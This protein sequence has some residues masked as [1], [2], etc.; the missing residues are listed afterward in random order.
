MAVS[1]YKSKVSIRGKEKVV[2]VANYKKDDLT[3]EI[4][5]RHHIIIFDRS[6]SMSGE[7]TELISNIKRVIEYIPENDYISILW[8]SGEGQYST[9]VKGARKG[10]KL[11]LL[12]DSVNSTV[13]CTCFSEVLKEAGEIIKELKVIC[14]NFVINLFT[15]GEA[16]TSVSDKEEYERALSNAR[17][18]TNDILALNTIGYGGYYNK[19]FLMELSEM[20]PYGVMCH[21][22]NIDEYYGILVE[23]L[24]R[25]KD[26]TVGELEVMAVNS[27]IMYNTS[28]HTKMTEGLYHTNLLDKTKNQVVIILDSESE[29]N[30]NDEYFNSKDI[31]KEIPSATMIP[32]MYS[33]AYNKYIKG[34]REDSISVLAD[35]LRDKYLVD[36]QFKA[37]S[38][39]E[40]EQYRKALNHAIYS[41]KARLLDGEC[42]E[43]YLPA[44]N[45]T[46]LMDIFKILI[47]GDSKYVY[48]DKYKRIG[49]KDEDSINLFKEEKTVPI[50]P[51]TDLTFNATRLN[52][53]I[54]S[55]IRGTVKLKAK[56]AKILGVDSKLSTRKFRNQAIVKDGALNID[57]ID[58]IVSKKV[59][60]ELNGLGIDGL[61]CN[62]VRNIGTIEKAL[63]EN[64]S[65]DTNIIGLDLR[66]VPII[67][68]EYAN[69]MGNVDEV[70]DNAITMN[71]LAVQ[72]KIINYFLKQT[73]TGSYTDEQK[74]ILKSYGLDSSLT[75]NA[76]HSKAKASEDGDFYMAR[77]IKFDIKGYA[78]I[79]AIKTVI[80]KIKAD[81]KLT[82]NA[83]IIAEELRELEKE[84]NRKAR[85]DGKKSTAKSAVASLSKKLQNEEVHKISLIDC[86]I[87]KVDGLIEFLHEKLEEVRLNKLECGLM[88]SSIKLGKVLTGSWFD[89]V[90]DDGD[91]NYSYHKDGNTLLIKTKRVR[92]AY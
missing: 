5:E 38:Y 78:S 33:Y 81:K 46:C 89:G 44:D 91:G 48:T 65:G 19:E 2:V 30:I 80:D 31:E 90:T 92:V 69:S 20:S 67:N 47:N 50:T 25:I 35:V 49:L 12:L 32:V 86:D 88:Q 84:F 8:F 1:L 70:L 28:K 45:A 24:D 71:R 34:E 18:Y 61:V 21:S 56:D 87:E 17:E 59:L 11:S 58:V 83:V 74:E 68:R 43:D 15:D 27:E 14:P 7:I 73:K 23:N 62:T 22:S 29:F 10:D 75:Y 51:L 9:L 82:G 42:Y 6:V 26:L 79:P 76:G 13:G 36:E 64:K 55:M 77:D 66:A 72:Q 4:T 54:Q 57:K 39:D 3:K 40:C 53:S 41:K 52:I 16:C 60:K 85:K 63:G 37:F